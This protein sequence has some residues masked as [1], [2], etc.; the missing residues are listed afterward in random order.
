M[1]SEP[2]ALRVRTARS[3]DTASVPAHTRTHRD[4]WIDAGLLALASGGPDAVRIEPLA[5]QLGVTRGGFYWH[6]ESREAFL[7]ELLDAWEHRS[8]NAVIE[9]VEAEGGDP[10]ERVR[11]AG[12]ETFSKDLVPIDLAVRDWARRDPAVEKRLRRV[13]DRRMAY[14]RSQIATFCSDPD[15][16]EARSMLAFSLAI[17]RHFIAARHDGRR[18]SDVLDRALA[19]ILA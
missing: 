12:I 19:R 16:V 6:F 7:G 1:G 14:L 11:R 10:R 9:R 18:R 17:G 5:K 4:T 3:G 13:D 2:R 15:E 8:T